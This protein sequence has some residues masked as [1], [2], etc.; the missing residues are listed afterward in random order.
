MLFRSY[1]IFTFLFLCRKEF[2]LVDRDES[3]QAFISGVAAQ[4]KLASRR[5]NKVT[6]ASM[7]SLETGEL[8]AVSRGPSIIRS[9]KRRSTRNVQSTGR[10][11]Y[12][13]EQYN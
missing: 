7:K 8:K 11:Q 1:D 12:K 10:I 9:V 13:P 4:K 5:G 6:C 3:K 2:E